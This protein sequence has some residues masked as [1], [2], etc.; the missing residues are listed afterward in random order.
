MEAEQTFLW[1]SVLF[2]ILRNYGNL[3]AVQSDLNKHQSFMETDY[4]MKNSSFS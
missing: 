3:T 4:S 2:C 1:V